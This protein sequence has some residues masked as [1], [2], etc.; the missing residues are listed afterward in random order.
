MPTVA[1]TIEE[2][3]KRRDMDFYYV[4]K[5][6]HRAFLDDIF[7][8]QP[9][10]YCPDG[11]TFLLSHNRGKTDLGLRYTPEGNI[12]MLYSRLLNS[13][14]MDSQSARVL[15]PLQAYLEGR[16]DCSI[17]KHGAAFNPDRFSNQTYPYDNAYFIEIHAIFD[18]NKDYLFAEDIGR[19]DRMITAISDLS[20]C[21]EQYLKK[22]DVHGNPLNWGKET[23]ISKKHL[24]KF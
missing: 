7:M 19:A 20:M 11:F 15:A 6:V 12:E 16:M 23:L 10:C 9:E 8:R 17:V 24:Q 18:E 14:E 3:V 4:F 2:R 22:I 21:G 5:F 1:A 13:S